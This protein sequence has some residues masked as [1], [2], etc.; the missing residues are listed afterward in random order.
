MSTMLVVGFPPDME[1]T[2]DIFEKLADGALVWR[3][4]VQGHDA[5][6]ARLRELAKRS[7]NEF[8]VHHLPTKSLVATLQLR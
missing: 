5:A 6:I 7:A 1:R 4:T 2:Y 3:D 8:Q